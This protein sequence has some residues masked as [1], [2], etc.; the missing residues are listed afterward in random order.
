[1]L[2]PLCF[3]A[4]PFFEESPSSVLMR[5]ALHN[6]YSSILNMSADLKI[7]EKTMG[8]W[9]LNDGMMC[10]TFCKAAPNLQEQ[11]KECFY[12]Q[13]Q[14]PLGRSDDVIVQGMRVPWMMLRRP[15]V[16]C[17]ICLEEGYTRYIQ[18]IADFKYCPYHAAEYLRKCTACQRP[19]KWR[20]SVDS[21]CLCGHDFRKSPVTLG[22][23]S[24]AIQLLELFRTQNQE[25]F[26]R[27]IAA[28]KCLK[29]RSL[30]TMRNADFMSPALQIG[31]KNR[32]A[33]HHIILGDLETYKQLHPIAIFFPWLS[34]EN[35]WIQATT[36]E[37][38]SQLQWEKKPCTSDYCCKH[39]GL[40]SSFFHKNLSMSDTALSEAVTGGKLKKTHCGVLNYYSSKNMCDFVNSQLEKI[41]TKTKN[42]NSYRSRF[43]H[44]SDVVKILHTPNNALK[45]LIKIGLL[46]KTKKLTKR[47]TL[48][49]KKQT[50]IFN[51]LYISSP[52]LAIELSL[53]ARQV[54]MKKIINNLNVQSIDISAFTHKKIKIY[55]RKLLTPEIKN[56]II[57][58]T[59]SIIRQKTKKTIRLS[60][61]SIAKQLKVKIST[62]SCMIKN[63][64]YFVKNMAHMQHLPDDQQPNALFNEFKK[65]RDSH[66]TIPEIT[67]LL[68]ITTGEFYVRFFK[69]KPAC[70]ENILRETFYDKAT[71][72]QMRTNA[73][74]YVNKR[75]AGL[76]GNFS[77][78]QITRMVRAGLI[79]KFRCAN[80]VLSTSFVLYH[81]TDILACKHALRDARN[82]VL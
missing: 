44:L 17:P 50:Q 39:F 47:V 72:K 75:N 26:N 1:M 67:Q 15:Q 14:K 51:S 38:Y 24:S 28:L 46:G 19:Y 56:Q 23:N 11:L 32:E 2:R 59:N 52:A 69:K 68:H 61:Q 80:H 20:N 65:W 22:D 10:A 70:L 55:P 78:S 33:L 42:T 30:D 4:N 77:E 76:L 58:L 41:K 8:E 40:T 54:T 53:V 34:S 43:Y 9:I 63:P 25:A 60:A 27:T 82:I 13:S 6:G 12:F 7:T 73:D 29:P 66:Y 5:T 64:Q 16:F 35:E 18:D 21:L 37:L 81:T 74:K 36:S 31:F 49:S 45:A 79:R 57:I 71:L 48:I 3:V 62:A